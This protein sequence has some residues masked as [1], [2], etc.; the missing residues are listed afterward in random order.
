[1]TEPYKYV[2]AVCAVL[3]P[4]R[5]KDVI[6]LV[7]MNYIPAYEPL[8]GDYAF[9]ADDDSYV[10]TSEDEMLDYFISHP[11][12]AQVFFWNQGKQNPSRIMVGAFLTTDEQLIVSLTLPAD[13]EREQAYLAELKAL[14][15]S[16][17]GV[18]SYQIPPPFDDGAD[19]IRRYG[20]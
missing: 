19:F 11:T 4:E 1:M 13:G 15:D 17:V 20:T 7:L 8:R 18:I 3:A 12:Q 16:S 2:D 14:L 10:F 6:R 9:P 5:T